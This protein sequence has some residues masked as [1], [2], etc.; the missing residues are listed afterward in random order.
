MD[1]IHGGEI[2]GLISICF[3]PL[4]SLPDANFT[5]AA[6]DRLEHYTAIDFFM[7]ETA[8]HADLILPGSLHEEDEGTVTTLEG[9]VVKINAATPPPGNARRD[10]EIFCE[11]ARRLDS[12]YFEY[13]S[14]EEIF[15]ELRVASSGGT[16][17][18]TGIT[19]QRV[20]DE[21]GVF[22]PCPEEGHPGTPR[23]YEGG[24]FYHPDGRARFI[25]T[26]WRPPA[27]EV[28]DEYPVWLT[29][30]RVISQYLSGTQTRRIGPLVD[31]YPEP[32]CEIHPRLAG[33][34]GVSDGDLIRVSSRRGSM[35]APA[36]VVETIR[37]D[38]VFIPYH[39]AGD[40]SANLLTIRALDPVSK[41]PEY[42]V[43]AVRIE[44][45]GGTGDTRDDR[46]MTLHHGEGDR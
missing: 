10:W 12:P 19:W 46:D 4:V 23:L 41:I 8:H 22:W 11:I 20:V 17:D 34:L 36:K 5:R 40:K 32:L 30:G 25:P 42:K 2:K 18:Y 16:A 6:L 24:K 39:W 28:D 1:A 38:T 14:T 27:E 15:E 29:T 26:P 9:R 35:V 44:K 31:Q 33:S 3:N 37:P 21:Q 7:S 13:G 43:A 45:T